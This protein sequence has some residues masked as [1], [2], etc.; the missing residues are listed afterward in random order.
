MV[1]VLPAAFT[2]F[3]QNIFNTP[4]EPLCIHCLEDYVF[5]ACEGCIIEAH[6]LK[7]NEKMARLRTILPVSELVYNSLGDCIVSLERRTSE[8][9]VSLRIYF[10]WHVIREL[11]TPMR[12]I[13]LTSSAH[14]GHAPL[15]LP[16]A[17]DAKVLELP[18][19]G[20]SCLW[21]MGT[22][23]M[24]SN[25]TVRLSH[26]GGGEGMYPWPPSQ[27]VALVLSPTWMPLWT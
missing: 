24:G 18:M 15:I 25:K 22:I 26:F 23:A 9:P 17:V 5:I 19:E 4:S 10:K 14:G 8:S 12:V 27:P 16:P 21:L 2:L 13:T 3:E 11:E 20:V 7:K 6:D 1:K